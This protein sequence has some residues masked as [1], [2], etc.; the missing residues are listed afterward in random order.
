MSA[1]DKKKLDGIATGAN[2]YTHPTTSGNKHIPSGGSSGQILRW[3]ADGTA[4]WG[5]DNNTTYSVATSSTDGLTPKADAADGTI[6]SSS[7]D[8]VLTSNNGSIGWYKLPANAFNNTTYSN[9]TASTAGLV[10]VSS[11]NSSAVTVNSESTTSGRYYPVELN[12]DGK[13]I[14]NVPW[15]DTNT[16]TKVTAVG[17]HYTPAADSTAELKIDASSTTSATWGS[18]DLV[19]GVNIQRD[20]KGHVTGVTVDSIQMPANPNVDTKVTNTLATTTKAYVTGTTSAST[21]TGGQVFDTGVYLDTTAGRL[22]A[23][24]FNVG[25]TSGSCNLVYDSTNKCVSF[26]FL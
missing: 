11:V 18:T 16:D 25:G 14:V 12:S 20:A 17:N 24:S 21:N 8:W 6:D 22:T 1:A 10:K 3:S 9:A 2:A 19:T 5:A 7:T 23:T 26:Q 15:S 4:A 13:A